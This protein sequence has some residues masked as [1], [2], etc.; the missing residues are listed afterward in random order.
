VTG[1]RAYLDYCRSSVPPLVP[2]TAFLDNIE[3]TAVFLRHADI[4][5]SGAT[6]IA[7][8]LKVG[9]AA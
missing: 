5:A 3:R 8:S 2:I 4:R 7:Q 6:A 9:A 1:K